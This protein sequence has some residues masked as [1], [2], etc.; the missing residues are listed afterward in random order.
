M[1]E[2]RRFIRLRVEYPPGTTDHHATKL[3]DQLRDF[4]G[5]LGD[6]YIEDEGVMDATDEEGDA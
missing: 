1:T 3:G 6:A 4:G 5:A 2:Q